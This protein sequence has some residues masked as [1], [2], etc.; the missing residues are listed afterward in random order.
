MD[1][2]DYLHPLQGRG[3]QREDV[4]ERWKKNLHHKAHEYQT[5]H[6]Q[7]MTFLI[8]AV[9]PWP[10]EEGTY[11]RSTMDGPCLRSWGPSLRGGIRHASR[12]RARRELDPWQQEEDPDGLMEQA[13]ARAEWLR[14]ELM[15]LQ[16]RVEN[17]SRRYGKLGSSYWKNRFVPEA[18]TGRVGD[19]AQCGDRA[20]HGDQA[21]CGDRRGMETKLNNGDRAWHGDQAQ[22]GDRARHGDQARC[23]DRA[24]HGDQAQ[25]RDWTVHGDQV[26]SGDRAGSS[27]E[28]HSDSRGNQ[29]LPKEEGDQLKGTNIIL[30]TLGPV[31]VDAGLQCGD[32]MAQLRP[33]MGDLS[34]SAVDWWDNMVKGGQHEVPGLV[35]GITPRQAQR[36]VSG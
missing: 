31:T 20:W 30:P 22:C 6:L 18:W 16:L 5:R 1:E 9:P 12:E 21:Q 11:D 23:G 32:W 4:Y 8:L 7:V 17:E 36:D 15:V 3:H 19:Q 35:G 10:L 29:G 27:G 14:Q 13:S 33:L 25:G 26:P 28:V 2:V 34:T 24:R